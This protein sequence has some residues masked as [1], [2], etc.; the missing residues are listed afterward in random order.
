MNVEIAQRL[1]ELRRERGFSQ[2]GLA[3]QLGLSRQAVSKW[4]RAESAPDMGNLIALADLYEVTLDELL[5]VSPEVEEDMRFESQE[6]AE[7]VETEAAAAAEAALAAAARAEAAAAT[8]AEAPDV[9][10]V[11]V[12]VSAPAASVPAAAPGGFPP[13]ASVPI[14]PPPAPR[15]KDPLQTFPYPLLC[16][17]IFLLAGFCF[18]W[19]HP[20]WVIFLTIPFY[21]WAVNTLEADPAYQAWLAERQDVA[22]KNDSSSEGGAR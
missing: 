1:A 12:E 2:E 7:S 3:E 22:T 14:A 11:V 18:G 6:R 4:E 10:K 17:V 13:S 15:P 16:A 19:W 21:Y 9:P 8:A 5:R 20:A